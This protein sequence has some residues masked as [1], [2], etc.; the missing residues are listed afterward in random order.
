ML[1]VLSFIFKIIAKFIS[2]LFTIDLGFT[3]LGVF[4]CIITFVFPIILA[5]I[6]IFKF[7]MKGD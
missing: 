4:I 7:K 2:M 1:D 5:I 6:N 3:S